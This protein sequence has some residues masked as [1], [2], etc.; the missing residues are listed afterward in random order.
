MYKQFFGFKEK[1]FKQAP[2]PEYL[3]LSKSHGETLTH[4]IFAISQGEGYVVVTG[5]DGTGKTTLCRAL[6][7]NLDE[8]VKAAY[9]SKPKLD[10]L[11]FLRTINDEFLVGPTPGNTK[12]IIDKLNGYLIKKRVA[13]KKVLLLIDEAQDLPLE[14]LEQHSLFSSPETIQEKLLQIILVGQPELDDMLSSP[15]LKQLGQCIT[16]NC[17]L[18][19]LTFLETEDYIRHRIS[20]ASRKTGPR[21]DK[22]SYRA[23][24]EYSQGIPRLI[25]IG[26]DMALQNAFNCNSSK[27]TGAITREAINELTRKKPAKSYKRLKKAPGLAILSAVLVP[28]VIVLLYFAKVQSPETAFI[29]KTVNRTKLL[30]ISGPINSEADK[31]KTP[32]KPPTISQS[33]PG[34][35]IS[36]NMDLHLVHVETFES[37]SQAKWRL[38]SLKS[39]GFPSFM[40]PRKSKTG[41]TVYEVIAGKYQSYDLAEE[42][43]RNLSQKGHF[44]TVAKA[45]DTLN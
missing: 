28:L 42:A 8:S 3:F 25:N 27:I 39:L 23:I 5:E 14:V 17:K 24:Y 21:F 10:A 43:S 38:K 4:L 45:E 32:A 37:A 16:Q 44:N 18:T 15:Q 11:Q 41:K 35:N 26:C 6:L 31:L 9:I 22:A 2:N 33:E 12:D 13:G 34:E 40:H 7:S 30:A 36:E 20:H 1:P 19:P 29:D